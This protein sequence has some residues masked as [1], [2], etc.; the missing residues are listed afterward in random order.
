MKKLIIGALAL[1]AVTAGHARTLSPEEALQRVE[2]GASAHA[3]AV[4]RTAPALVAEG[5]SKAVP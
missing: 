3:K 1:T 4:V 2:T 5:S